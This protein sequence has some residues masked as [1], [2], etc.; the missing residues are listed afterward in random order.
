MIRT[1]LLLLVLLASTLSARTQCCFSLG[2]KITFDV[3]WGLINA[4]TA[5]LEIADTLTLRGSPVW[6]IESSARSNRALS[7]LYPVRD[8][9]LTF[10]DREG[11]YSHGMEKYLR[12]GGYKSD[13]I[14]EFDYPD[15][16]ARRYKHGVAVDSVRLAKHVQDVLSAFYWVRTQ[17]LEVGRSLQMEAMDDLKSYRMVV[18]VLGRERVKVKAGRFDCFL[19]Q[20]LLLGEGL[21]KSEG[22]VF[23]W[24][25][26]D[27]RHIPVKMRSEI[28]I[29][30]ISAVMTDYQPGHCIESVL[31]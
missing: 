23:I 27:E 7:V 16:V 17:E 20:P 4:G 18:Q 5:V 13:R 28:F 21:F 6:R 10:M 22:E 1:A 8:R 9:V 26:A 15:Q 30:A 3:G 11:F 14:F 12:E 24:L 25:S 19:V 2:E 31:P 29:G